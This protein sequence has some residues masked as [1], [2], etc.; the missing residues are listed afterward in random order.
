MI[1]EHALNGVLV[2]IFEDLKVQDGNVQ[3]LTKQ[4]LALRETLC[5]LN[6]Q[7][8]KVYQEKFDALRTTKTGAD[9]SVGAFYDEIIRKLRAGLLQGI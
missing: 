1:D 9:D 8:D 6:P 5:Q 2:D 4:V 7:F 3:S